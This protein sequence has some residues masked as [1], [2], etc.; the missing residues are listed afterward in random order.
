MLNEIVT[1]TIKSLETSL[2]KY[3]DN[4][5]VMISLAEIYLKCDILGPRTLQLL[6]RLSELA[7]DNH[8][9]HQPLSICYLIHQPTEMASNLQTLKG[10]D[11]KALKEIR[12][13]LEALSSQHSQS[14]DLFKALG[15]IALFQKSPNEAVPYY[16]EAFRLGFSDFPLI[17]RSFSLAQRSYEL[18]PE[19]TNFI[20]LIYD[21]IGIPEKA[22]DLF[23]KSL[24]DDPEN[25]EAKKWLINYLENVIS[26]EAE[27]DMPP[28]NKLELISLYLEDRNIKKALEIARTL[29]LDELGDYAIIKKLGRVL[30]DMED[31]R[32][33][34]DFLSRIPLDA[35]NKA[36]INEI[37]LRLE[38]LGELDTAVYLLQFINTHDMVIVE[39]KEWEDKELKTNTE[40]GLAELHFKN[41]KW[42]SALEK[43]VS[44]LKMDYEDWIP[45]L[46]KL[47]EI[48]RSMN[49]PPLSHMIY[50]G[51]F[52]VTQG[53]Y[54]KAA[55][56]LSIALEHYPGDSKIQKKLRGVYDHLLSLNPRLPDLRLRSGDLAVTM[57]DNKKAL[58]EYELV[59]QTPE[60]HLMAGKRIARVYDINGD[61][62]LAFEKYKTMEE[63]NEE[64]CDFLYSLYEK[65]Y[66]QGNI[67]M[68]SDV[69]KLIYD[70]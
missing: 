41:R 42:D 20:A 43:Y 7:P 45:I 69:L 57:G 61:Y 31:Y 10:I 33:S 55:Q 53:N 54:H 70:Y 44:I 56:Y 67:P 62:V 16:Q 2:A 6:E 3:P 19:A 58:T 38:R 11:A 63:I 46:E 21:K 30:I 4:V 65:I 15:D 9:I 59:S 48:L 17:I 37:T 39:A 27:L 14:A 49:T 12:K 5:Q 23:R 52:C 8:R 50:L 24:L 29:N 40:L 60:L 28:D 34:F 35:E 66:E 64:D 47:D 68:A 25:T 36:L 1:K 22:A 32:Q 26:Q 51:D 18:T 13:R